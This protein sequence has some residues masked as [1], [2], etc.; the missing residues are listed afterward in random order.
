MKK[1]NFVA[2]AMVLLVLFASA[3]GGSGN[4]V[5]PNIEATEEEKGVFQD[6]LATI[7]IEG[8]REITAERYSAIPFKATI[9]DGTEI[10]WTSSDEDVAIVSDDGTALLVGTGSAVITARK[11]TNKKI[12]ASVLIK[13]LPKAEETTGDIFDEK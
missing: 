10:V 4:N 5:P 3:C 11:K 8:A 13:V 2:L 1:R 6:E 12:F 7:E 9:S